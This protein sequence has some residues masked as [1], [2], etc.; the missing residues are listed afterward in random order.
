[1]AWEH[2][3]KDRI[4]LKCV[5]DYKVANMDAS[6]SQFLFFANDFSFHR[7]SFTPHS[8]KTNLNHPFQENHTQC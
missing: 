7:N 6:T 5:I 2:G 3:T 1:M 8:K 4:R